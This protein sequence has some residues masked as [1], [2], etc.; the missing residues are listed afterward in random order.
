MIVI[1]DTNI[2]ISDLALVSNAGSAVRFY[3]RRQNAR[4]GLPE[5]VRLE[6]EENLRAMLNGHMDDIQASHRQLLAVFGRLKEVVLPSK[7]EV[8]TLIGRIFANLGVEIH[9]IPFTLDNASAALTRTIRKLP[10]SDRSQQFKDCVIWEN[11]LEALKTE[12]VTLVTNDKAFYKGGDLSQGLA[13]ALKNDLQ[14]AVNDFR[15][16]ASLTALLSEIGTG[17]DVDKAGLLKAYLA[18]H[19]EK[20]KAMAAGQSFVMEGEPTV[21]LDAV[22]TEDP[23]AL[24]INFAIEFPCADQTDQE[25]ENAKIISRG[26]GKYDA[27]TKEFSQLADRGQQMLYRLKDGTEQVVQN[28]VISVGGLVI[29]HRAVEHSVRFKF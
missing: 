1:I 11:C 2:W 23:K 16:Y 29:G 3:L 18:G 20:L 13:A 17:P 14:H 10:P 4:I 21:T 26:E 24:F 15:I 12:A 25:R 6:T 7:A 27:V 8:E 22:V 5:V 28:Q 19:E 9:E